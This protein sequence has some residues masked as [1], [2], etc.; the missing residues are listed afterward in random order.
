MKHAF[1]LAG[2]VAIGLLF[3]GA[4]IAKSHHPAGLGQVLTSKDGGEI[5]GFAVNQSG[6]DGVLATG[7]D[8]DK[9]YKVSVETFDQDTGEITGSFARYDGPR[10]SY[11]VEGIFAGDVGLVTHYIVPK[12]EI[13]PKRKYEVMNP[14]TANA[15]TGVW[16]PP[17]KN[18]DVVMAS[19]DQNSSTSAIFARK[20]NSGHPLI[21]VSDVAANTFSNII[22]LDPNLFAGGSGPLLGQFTAAN[23]A[24]L[25]LNPKAWPLN[26]LVDLSTGAMTQ[27]KGYNN[28]K[29]GAGGING[30]AVD[31]NTGIAATTT[32][33]NA[34]VEFYDLKAMHGIRWQQLPCTGDTSELSS[35]TGIAVDPIHQRFLVTEK[36]YCDEKQGSAILVYNERGDLV[37]TITG[38]S[39]FLGEPAP[40]IN[41]NKRMGW[42]FGGPKGW[43]QLQQFFY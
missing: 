29:Y 43:S 40:A 27:F 24:M 14:V 18:I 36:V 38:F 35:G 10:H 26:V 22:R 1:G 13:Y 41:P 5:F 33:I 37:E 19:T 32:E 9:G 16:T 39:F 8:T 21:L 30:L 4:A 25:A 6:D 17:L 2:A 15:F 28:G 20:V 31:P 23:Q 42:A 3:C 12:G 34:Q 11:S 7:Q